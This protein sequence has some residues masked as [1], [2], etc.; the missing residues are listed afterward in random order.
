MRL[1]IDLVP[2]TAWYSNLRTKIS[3]KEWDKIRKK[4][5]AEAGHKCMICRAEEK[6]NCHEIW[7]YDDEKYVQ[8]LKD[9][10]ALCDDCHMIKHIGFASI[11]ANKGLLDME[12]LIKHFMIVNNVDRKTFDEYHEKSFEIWKERS[13]SKWKTDLAEWFNLISPSKTALTVLD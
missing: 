13:K 2:S 8:K 5:Y 9:F 1:E 12:K 11:Q 6:L 10:I 4:S 3:R 7:E